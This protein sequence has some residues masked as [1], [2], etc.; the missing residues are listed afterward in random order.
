VFVYGDP[1]QLER[2]LLNLLGNA[3]KFTEPGG[4]AECWTEVYDH[5]SRL[6]VRDTGVGIPAEEQAA[7]FQPF[8]RSS[9]SRDR[10]IPGTGLGLSISAAI[11]KA[12]GG[13]IDVRSAHLD[14]TTMTVRLPLAQAG[15]LEV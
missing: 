2:V 10:V 9:T 13:R 6:V 4:D 12:H 8:F 3:V 11:V 7:M 5:E 1:G 14:G 15:I